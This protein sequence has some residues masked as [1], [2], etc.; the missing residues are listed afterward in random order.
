L[1]FI[2]ASAAPP[3]GPGAS[4]D[5]SSPRNPV[6]ALGSGPPDST[7]FAAD[8]WL[9]TVVEHPEA[10]SA[11]ANAAAATPAIFL[12]RKLFIITITLQ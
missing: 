4:F 3:S 6:T 5:A 11:A 1:G 12:F 7:A 9:A 10:M 2:Q 8:G